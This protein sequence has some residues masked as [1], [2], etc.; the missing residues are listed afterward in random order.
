MKTDLLENDQSLLPPADLATEIQ[1]LQEEL[2]NERDRH[3]RSLADFK[4]YRRRTEQDMDKLA[5]EGKRSLLLGLLE[6]IDDIENAL[7]YINDADQPFAKGLRNIHKKFLT[8]L[9]VQGVIPF[10]SLGNLFNH[11]LHEAVAMVKNEGG[12]QGVVVDDLRRGYL[13]KNELLRPAQVRVAE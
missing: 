5:E 3:L 2:L 6:V 4:N 11:N 9:E 1:G 12:E 7:Q 8:L 10:E 13:W